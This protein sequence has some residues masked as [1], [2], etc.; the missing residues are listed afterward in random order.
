MS[1]ARRSET[2][3]QRCERAYAPLDLAGSAE[4]LRL[5]ERVA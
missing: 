3:Q 1:V 5:K 4:Q 2:E